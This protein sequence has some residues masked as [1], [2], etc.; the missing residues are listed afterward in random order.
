M[1]E[2]IRKNVERNVTNVTGGDLADVQGFGRCLVV[3]ISGTWLQVQGADGYK[4]W[5]HRRLVQGVRVGA[6]F[7]TLPGPTLAK[8]GL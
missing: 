5:V 3:D 7:G 6:N 2:S 4:F 8:P 1:S